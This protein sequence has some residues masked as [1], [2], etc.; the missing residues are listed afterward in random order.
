MGAKYRVAIIGTGRM[1]GLI[2]DEIPLGDPNLPYGHF[3]AY[4]YIEETEVV[5]VANRGAERLQRFSER[6]GITNTYLDYREMIDKEQPDIV[7]VTAPS[8][9]RAE[10]LRQ[11]CWK[12][13]HALVANGILGAGDQEI[14]HVGLYTDERDE[15]SDSRNFVLCPGGAYDR[16]PCGTG[17]SAKVACLHADGKLADGQVWRQKGLV[18]SIFQGS[19]SRVGD[20]VHPR[21]RGRAYIT[22]ESTLLLDD[23][24]PFRTGI[25][26]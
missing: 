20:R 4:E 22:A 8:F 25:T 23:A 24:D 15:D 3:S 19:V 11:L 13:R 14:D 7:S 9:A 12:I 6:F 17:T 5:A 21:I 26:G 10:P 1:G 16:S 2:E 18:G